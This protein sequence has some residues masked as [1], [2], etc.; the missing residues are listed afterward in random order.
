MYQTGDIILIP[1]PFTN[2]AKSKVRPAVVISSKL[3][4]S[5]NDLVLLAITSKIRDD[6]FSYQLNDQNLLN[7]MPRD[8]EIR[9]QK[10]FTASSRIVLKKINSIIPEKLD[11]LLDHFCQI[12]RS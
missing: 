11:S 10:V 8:S 2:L 5:T 12:I 4:N 6:A 9:C 1:F 7:P 3:V